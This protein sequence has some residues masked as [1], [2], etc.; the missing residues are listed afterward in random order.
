MLNVS[1]TMGVNCCCCCCCC[2]CCFCCWWKNVT[3]QVRFASKNKQLCDNQ[4]FAKTAFKIFKTNRISN[5][6]QSPLKTNSK[7]EPQTSIPKP[8]TTKS[9]PKTQNPKP[10][11][12]KPKTPDP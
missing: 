6:A 9:E 4:C 11:T 10:K 1:Q 2:G 5:N 7:A 8:Q 3:H 12:P